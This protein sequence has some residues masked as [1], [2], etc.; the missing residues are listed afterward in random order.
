M[1][2]KAKIVLLANSVKNGLYCVAGINI[3][4]KEWIRIVEDSQGKE[5]SWYN[6]F[7][8][9]TNTKPPPILSLLEIEIEQRYPYYHQTENCKIKPNITYLEELSKDKLENFVQNPSV[10]WD[11]NDR[12]SL[13]DIKNRKVK[14]S[15][16][17]IKVDKVKLYLKDRAEY[18]KQPQRRASFKYNGFEYDLA[19]TDVKY[20]N[21]NLYPIEIENPYLVVSLGEPFRGENFD[22][23]YCFKIVAGIITWKKFSQ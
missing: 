12:M 9:N 1:S 11:I 13:S 17:L 19:I 4:N 7:I 2:E 22:D 14:S 16:Y 21:R 15:L 6:Y 3:E 5:I 8:K 23:Y 20:G 18:N 10:L